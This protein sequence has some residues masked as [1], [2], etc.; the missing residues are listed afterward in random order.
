[1]RLYTLTVALAILTTMVTSVT[2]TVWDE[3][4]GRRGQSDRRDFLNLQ[5]LRC[6]TSLAT[7]QYRLKFQQDPK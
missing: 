7:S 5:H 3:S 2:V 4:V 1:M 6:S